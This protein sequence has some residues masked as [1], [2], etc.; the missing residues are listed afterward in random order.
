M[1]TPNGGFA[2]RGASGKET[3]C[4]PCFFVLVMEVLNHLLRWVEQRGLLTAIAGLPGPQVSLYADD[5]VLFVVPEER[6]LEAVKAALTIFILAS[7]L[8][9]NVEKSVAMPL[10]CSDLHVARI[11]NI[12]SCRIE[13]FPCRYLGVLLSVYKLKRRSSP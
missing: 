6:D 9:S 3:L 1:G 5:L 11:Q 2:M 12:L 8:F 7:G 13:D 10:H 4:R